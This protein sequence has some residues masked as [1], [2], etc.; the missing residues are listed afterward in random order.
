MEH[1]IRVAMCDRCVDWVCHR[2]KVL[3][4]YCQKCSINKK[5]L[6]AGS[7]EFSFWKEGHKRECEANYIGSS[8]AMEMTAALNL[9]Q[10]SRN[11]RIPIHDSS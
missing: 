6:G 8:P 7:T 4:Q 3:S 10:R 1:G 11:I 9:W 2:Y 5:E